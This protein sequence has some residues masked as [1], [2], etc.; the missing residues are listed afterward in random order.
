MLF[1]KLIALRPDSELADDAK[2][3]LAESQFFSQQLDEARQSFRTLAADEQADDFV[4]QRALVLLMDIDWERKDWPAV[5]A[6]ARDLSDR[7]PQGEQRPFAQYRLGEGLVQT[8]NMDEAIQV[9]GPLHE[10]TVDAIRQAEWFA[11]V[12]LLLAE[13]QVQIKDYPAVEAT[14][15][16][17]RQ[18]DPQ[19]K[20]LYQADEI[21]GRRFK[22]EARWDESREALRRVVDS[23]EGRRTETAA[24][25][26]TAPRRDVSVGDEGQRGSRRVLQGVPQL[27]LPGLPGSCTLPGGAV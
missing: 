3:Y 23:T 7:F 11:G 10:S 16:R 2:L 6:T 19:S 17:F 8:G 5:L 27:Q 12:R 25:G 4:R 26:P 1:D 24:E 15:A 9:L 13:A 21:L 14:V 18:E 20:L 22:N